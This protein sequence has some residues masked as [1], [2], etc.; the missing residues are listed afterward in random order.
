MEHKPSIAAVILAAGAS[1]R[2]GSAKQVARVGESTMLE[3]VLSL[4]TAANLDPIIAVVPPGMAR[5]HATIAVE[6]DRPEL[7]MSRSLQLGIEALPG[8]AD[9][10][11]ILLA[12]QPTVSPGDLARLI[13]AR[14]GHPF[15]ATVDRAG[16]AAPP[17]LIERSGFAHTLDLHGDAGLRHLLRT[18]RDLVASVR[19][20]THAPDVDTPADFERLAQP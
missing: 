7:G 20:D 3:A 13:A 6:N 15:V 12:D 14:D 1:T 16:L 18:R 8:E 19:V 4:A 17:V 11:V 9:A 5:P 10:A 2:F